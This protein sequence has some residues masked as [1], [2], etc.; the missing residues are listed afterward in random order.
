MVTPVL[1]LLK[2]KDEVGD[3]PS[4]TFS[5]FAGLTDAI[6]LETLVQ[7]HGKARWVTAIGQELVFSL[8]QIRK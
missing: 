8:C 7:R 5:E 1:L 3:D 2:V 4:E 6:A